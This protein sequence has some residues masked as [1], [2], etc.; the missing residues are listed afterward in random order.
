MTQFRSATGFDSARWFRRRIASRQSRISNR[1]HAGATSPVGARSRR[2]DR[3]GQRSADD[4]R[5]AAALTQTHFR[6]QRRSAAAPA[7]GAR[8]Q[9]WSRLFTARRAAGISFSASASAVNSRASTKPAIPNQRTRRARDRGDTGDAEAACERRAHRASRRIFQL[10]RNRDAAE[11]AKTP[12]GPPVWIGGRA[13]G[14]LRRAARSATD[15]CRM[16]SRLIDS[17]MVSIGNEAER[18]GCKIAA[19]GTCIQIFCTLG[20]SVEA[21]HAVAGKFL[22]K[23]YAVI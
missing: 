14:P 7:S 20:E 10:R 21:A 6:H 9:R 11:A 12:G 4:A 8:R 15:G 22:S 19:F 23:R 2:V 3:A 1:S 18:A 5:I 17:P 16:S 13:E